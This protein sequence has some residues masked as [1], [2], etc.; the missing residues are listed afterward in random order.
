MKNLLTICFALLFINVSAQTDALYDLDVIQKFDITFE[1]E[2]W[3]KK[4]D[5]L[6]LRGKGYLVGNI[7]INGQSFNDVGIKYRG[8]KSFGLGSKKNAIKI[9]LNH[10]QKDQQYGGYSVIKVSNALRDPS[11]VREVLGYHIAGKYF[12]AP[13]ANYCKVTI[14]DENFGLYVNIEAIDEDTFLERAFGYT[15]GALFEAGERKY[16]KKSIRRCL[17]GTYGALDFETN[18]E[19]Y[20]QNFHLESDNE[21]AW[22]QLEKLVSTLNKDVDNIGNILDIDQTLWMLAFNN[23]T[24][25]LSSYTGKIAE[26]YYLFQQEDGRFVPIVHDLNLAFGSYKN[27]G[28]GSDLSIKELEELSPLLHF[29]SLSKPLISKLLKNDRYR[30]IYLSHIKTLNDEIFGNG[31]FAEK[32]LALQKLIAK[33]VEM[34]KNWYYN[35]QDFKNSLT[36]TIGKSSKIPGIETFTDNRSNYLEKHKLFLTLY[37][38]IDVVEFSKRKQYGDPINQFKFKVHTLSYAKKVKLVYKKKG[39]TEWKETYMR[40]VKTTK[41]KGFFRVEVDAKTQDEVIEYYLV[42]EGA[43]TLNYYPSNYIHEKKS[44]S[45]SELNK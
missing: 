26:N 33:E 4:L 2:N 45:L 8:Q 10:T 31:Y 22:N 16:S 34:D 12:N 37:P 15:E 11:L 21:K 18:Q 7:K 9:K 35:G 14:N 29:K 25:N 36:K 23:V 27:T 42:L 3:A 1:D 5:S 43:T 20:K 44:V 41:D 19:C 28:K 30:K 13:K 24:A 17:E 6:T 32:T 39:E 40:S 38:R